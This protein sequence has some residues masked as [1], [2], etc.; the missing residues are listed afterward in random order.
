[1]KYITIKMDKKKLYFT[2]NEYRMDDTFIYFT[3]NKGIEKVF[4][5][6]NLIEVS[7]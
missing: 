6:Q 7:G 1:M 5:K 2:T 3:D 4:N